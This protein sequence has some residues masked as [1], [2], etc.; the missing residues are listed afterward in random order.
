MNRGEKIA[1]AI[2][3]IMVL[4]DMVIG[5]IS[6]SLLSEHPEVALDLQGVFLWG[7]ALCLVYLFTFAVIFI[8]RNK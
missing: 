4:I 5:V 8:I 7:V 1:F 6:M 2:G 3:L